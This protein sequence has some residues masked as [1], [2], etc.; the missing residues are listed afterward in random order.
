MRVTAIAACA[1]L[2]ASSLSAQ[3]AAP[4]AAAQTDFSYATPLPGNWT[5]APVADGSEATYLNATA[6]PQLIVHCTKAARRVSIAKPA[7]GAVPLLSI[8]T[9]SQ[10]RNVP[11][12]FNPATA[13]LTAEFAAFD[14]MLDAIAF[15][16]GRAAFSVAGTPAL[17]VPAWPEIARVVEDCRS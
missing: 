16:R 7:T 3:T 8:W 1:L 13:R 11:A 14:P 17:V 5:Y 9:S 15:S 10:T 4:P 6:R 2:T 12:S